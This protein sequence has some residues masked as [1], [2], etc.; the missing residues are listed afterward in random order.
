MSRGECDDEGEVVMG[1]IMGVL[2]SCFVL[3][4]CDMTLHYQGAATHF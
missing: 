3:K 1:Q 2:F 4:E